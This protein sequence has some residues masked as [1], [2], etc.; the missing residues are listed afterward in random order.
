MS[1][2]EI[3]ALLR[4]DVEAIDAILGDKKFLFGDRISLVRAKKNSEKK[5]SITLENME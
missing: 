3:H 5:K 1:K 2:D 4:K